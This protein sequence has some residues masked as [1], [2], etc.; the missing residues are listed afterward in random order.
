MLEMMLLVGVPVGAL[1]VLTLLTSIMFRVVVST[2]D[3]HIV[4]SSR[5]TTSYGKDHAAGNTY[6]RWPSW[7]PIIGV[8]TITLPMSVFDQKLDA[9]HAYDK[10]R[11]PFMVD[12]IAFFR[13]TDSNV[14]AQR[15][16]SFPELLSQL[17]NILQ[18]AIRTILASHE[19]EE[20]LEG[21][22]K[23]GEAFTKEVDHQLVE[24][25][26]QNVKC[27]ELMDIRDAQGSNVIA[28]IMAKKKSLIEMQ[29]RT[30]VAMNMRMAQTAEI[31]AHREVELRKQE[32]V[33]SIGIRTAEQER[34]V[35]VSK[36][37]AQ[38][39]IKEQARITAEKDMAVKQVQNVRT[40]EIT[41]Q[42]QIVAAAQ[43]KE[44]EI[45]KAEGLRQQTILVAEGNLQG[46][47]LSSEGIAVEGAARAEAEKL[48]QLAP[49]QAQITLAQEIGENKGYQ[50]YLIG[51]RQIEANQVVG[52]EQ[53][54]ALAVAEIKVIANA[55]SPTDGVTDVMG[56]FTPKGGTQLG[57]MVEAFKQ[58]EGGAAIVSAV[59]NAVTKPNGAGAHK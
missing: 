47:K 28:N 17:E 59:T 7:V 12:I 53:A 39:T 49:V 38:Q 42:V 2:N 48:M 32:A 23:F 35:G 1:I 55:G 5:H 43:Q 9:Y 45:I 57:A 10:G 58:T 27:I 13:V 14:A 8:Q 3:V 15:V 50:T 11:V 19:I 4:Q 30:E 34:D 26:V 6:Y 25:G 29:S 56:L 51:I 22:S 21:R 18:G 41:K 24:W 46:T 40:A 31:D 37:Q 16:H 36:E 52:V 33:Q 20:I 44:T 54:K